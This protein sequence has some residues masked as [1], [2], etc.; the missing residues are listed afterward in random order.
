[1]IIRLSNTLLFF[2]GN[3][4][5]SFAAVQRIL[6]FF[7]QKVYIFVTFPFTFLLNVSV[8]AN[9]KLQAPGCKLPRSDLLK[10]CVSCDM[11][12]RL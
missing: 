11:A 7:Q 12:H 8:I 3:F 6:T 10:G 4:F 2:V 9:F 1:M 5:E